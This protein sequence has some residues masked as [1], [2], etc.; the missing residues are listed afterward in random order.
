MGAE[1]GLTGLRVAIVHDWL[2]TWA[3]AEKVLAEMLEVL[4]QADLYVGVYDPSLAEERLPGREVK[5]TFI[6]RLTGPGRRKFRLLLLLMPAAFEALDLSGY[7]LVIS[8][9]HSFSKCVIPGE[10]ALHFCYC[11]T[12]PRYLWHQRRLYAGRV[13]RPGRLLWELLC[14]Y[15]RAVDFQA[16]QRVDAFMAV[17]E[18]VARR[19][20]RFYRREAEVVHPPVEVD[21]FRP[22]A[23]HEGFYLCVSRLVPYKRVDIAVEAA[24]RL[25]RRLVVVGD[26]PERRRL[27]AMAAGGSVEFLGHIPERE[28]VSLYERCRALVFPAEEDFGLAMVEA[29]AAGKPVVA[30]G[31]GGAAEI[32]KDGETGVLFDRQ[33]AEALCEAILKLE[34]ERFDVGEIRRNA[35]RFSRRAFR[36]AFL[37]F[38]SRHLGGG[39]GGSAA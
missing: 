22:T 6:Q 17:S 31:R 14:S 24:R 35:E 8:S 9:S 4:P 34:K 30:Y 23:E 36:D 13:A 37:S 15:L 25:G 5:A 19:I 1:E 26:G 32:V 11:Y 33:E 7:D 38:L 10:G 12:P 29:Q 20:W 28:L 2:V 18:A 21:K 3:G 16:A 39:K 27:E